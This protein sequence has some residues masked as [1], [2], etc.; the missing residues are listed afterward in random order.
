[1]LYTT[2]KEDILFLDI[3]TVPE[4]Y[5]FDD[6]DSS[7]QRLFEQKTAWRRQGEMTAEDLYNEAGIWAE[8][9]KVVTVAF[10]AY[11]PSDDKWVVGSVS[12]D[13]E[14]ALLEKVS[15]ILQQFDLKVR[16]RDKADRQA[17]KVHYQERKAYLCAHNGKEF[18]F[19]FLA[20]RM[21]IN[22]VPLPDILKMHGKKP[23]ETPYCDT[24]QLWRFGDHKHYVSLELLARILGLDSPKNDISGKDVAR[25][26]YEEHDLERIERYC[27]ND[28]KTLIGIF[29]RL[30]EEEPPP[31][32][33]W[34]FREKT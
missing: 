17:R 28:V 34:L 14:K 7:M 30:R 25:V 1:M 21:L 15:E 24:L 26:Y 32:D 10:G 31:A 8:F 9:G 33:R 4:I 11:S 20:R 5:R 12:D 13:D 6:L 27:R 18:D 23:W 19:P 3:E 2:P 29:H 16:Q 22:R